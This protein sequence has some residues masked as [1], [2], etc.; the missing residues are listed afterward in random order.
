MKVIACEL[1]RALRLASRE[2][3]NQRVENCFRVSV[4]IPIKRWKFFLR[5]LWK[6]WELSPPSR[7]W[8]PKQP[9]VDANEV[10][11]RHLVRFQPFETL[12][13]AARRNRNKVAV[14]FHPKHL[15]TMDGWD[16]NEL[17]TFLWSVK[18]NGT[19]VSQWQID[20]LRE[21]GVKADKWQ[22]QTWVM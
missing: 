11:P 1:A 18:I 9:V 2:H 19:F 14:I 5:A 12:T 8:L 22:N 10:T 3:C 20:K 4:Y 16:I 15:Y 13:E 6:T 17:S 7:E 21:W